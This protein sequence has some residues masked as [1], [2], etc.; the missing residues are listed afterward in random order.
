MNIP[1]TP[2]K[3]EKK[4][5][6]SNQPPTSNQSTPEQFSHMQPPVPLPSSSPL[7]KYGQ[8][9]VTNQTKQ[10][11]INTSPAS[12]IAPENETDEAYAKRILSEPE[13]MNNLLVCSLVPQ[14][15]A[16]VMK[17]IESNDYRLFNVGDV[18][19][20]GFDNEL[21]YCEKSWST[22]GCNCSGQ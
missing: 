4:N 2:N 18:S 9:A 21:V 10:A 8:P 16:E 17:L 20:K 13:M 12:P 5:V 1:S 11:S 3:E 22:C 6:P 19:L 14:M 7:L 15:C